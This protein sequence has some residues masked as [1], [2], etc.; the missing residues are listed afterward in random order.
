MSVMGEGSKRVYSASLSQGSL[1]CMTLAKPAGTG[2]PEKIRLHFVVSFGANRCVSSQLYSL[3]PFW[4]LKSS[5]FT[6]QIHNF[7]VWRA[8][9]RESLQ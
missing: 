1:S 6:Y 8:V 4:S 9:Q 3:C 7:P 5:I 2:E